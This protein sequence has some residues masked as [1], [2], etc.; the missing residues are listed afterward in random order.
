MVAL[1]AIDPNTEVIMLVAN[2]EHVIELGEHPSATL[3]IQNISA[4]NVFFNINETECV[5][6]KG[7]IM[8]P[9]ETAPSFPI[10]CSK[11][12]LKSATGGQV[13]VIILREE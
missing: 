6:G 3:V 10:Q 11:I 13:Q 7:D 1:R 12:R 5:G 4:G 8:I 2:T 9:Q